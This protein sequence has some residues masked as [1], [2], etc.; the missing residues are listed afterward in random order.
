M[1]FSTLE[2]CK[3]VNEFCDIVRKIIE[4]FNFSDFSLHI[5]GVPV[6]MGITTLT[7]DIVENLLGLP[8]LENFEKQRLSTTIDAIRKIP[9][10]CEF[11]RKHLQIYEHLTK[12]GYHDTFITQCRIKN[13]DRNAAL[14]LLKKNAAIEEFSR[15]LKG[16]K[17]S[18]HLIID[19][20]AHFSTAQFPEKMLSEYFKMLENPKMGEKL[21]TLLTLLAKDGYKLKEAADQLCISLDTANKHMSTVKYKLRANTAAHAAYKATKAGLI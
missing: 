8:T 14:F 15:I 17:S 7:S 11:K 10:N 1:N 20:I 9:V 5:I 4:E 21:L 2:N 3:D 18:L 19:L 13:L 12:N 16:T 6:S